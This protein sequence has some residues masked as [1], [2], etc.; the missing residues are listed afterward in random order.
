MKA[1]LFLLPLKW[2]LYLVTLLIPTRSNLWAFGSRNGQFVDNPKYF[3]LYMNEFHTNVDCIWISSDNNVLAEL[4]SLGFSAFNKWSFK[5]LWYSIRASRFI[6]A[7]D[8][9]DVNFFS[10]SN[11]QL[12][13]LYHGIPLKKIEFD[14]TVGSS[15]LIY[16]PQTFYQIIRSKLL[17]ATKWQPIDIFQVPS[18][19]LVSIHELAFNQQISKYHIGANP[20]LA[21]LLLNAPLD[22]VIKSDMKKA[23]EFVTGFTKVMIYMPTWRVGAPD[24]LNEA[25]PDIEHLNECLKENNILL[26]LKMH[27]YSDAKITALSH[28]KTFPQEL[29]IYPFMSVVDVLITDYSSIAFDFDLV[30]GN[31][32]FY[33]YDLD[34]YCLNSSDGFYFDYDD[35][36]NHAMLTNFEQLIAKILSNEF[37]DDRL[38]KN[39]SQQVWPNKNQASVFESNKRLYNAIVEL[40]E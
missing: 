35:F 21:P 25:F 29:D 14:T 2:L 20:R 16:H 19:S 11:S 33:P 4:S 32:L 39:I 1:Y 8:S 37:D 6:Y 23:K 10:S 9:D 5:G 3:F 27:L 13:N 18:A 28:I 26:I 22:D 17:Y 12:V 36:T 30:D 34:D 38:G 7:F 15:H 31:I 24:I 40:G